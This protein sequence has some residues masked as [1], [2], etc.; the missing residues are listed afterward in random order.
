M[1]WRQEHVNVAG[2]WVQHMPSFMD[3]KVSEYLSDIGSD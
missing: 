3:G 1:A 2:S